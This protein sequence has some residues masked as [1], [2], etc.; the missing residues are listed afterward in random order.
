MKL[1]KGRFGS[2]VSALLANMLVS[3]FKYAAMRRGN[4]PKDKRRDFYLYVDECHNLPSEN[5]TELLAEARKFRMGLVLATQY[6]AQISSGDARNNFLSA[7][8]GN[9]GT[10]IAFRLGLEDAKVMAPVFQPY[11]S[12]LDIIGLPNWQGYTRLQQGNDA[13]PP[14]SFRSNRDE[15]IFHD[16]RA[17]RIKAFSS[18]MYGMDKETVEERIRA[19]RTI[20]Q[21]SNPDDARE[22]DN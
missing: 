22:E 9:V 13:I 15:T 21:K 7:V 14:F 4:L 19:Q 8:I 17:E 12:A 16:D 1:G 11:F 2:Q 6:T 10:I 18:F 3:R 20:W 5:F